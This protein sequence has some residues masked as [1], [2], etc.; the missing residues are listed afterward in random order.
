MERGFRRTLEIV[1]I[2]QKELILTSKLSKELPDR[3][4]QAAKACWGQKAEGYKPSATDTDVEMAGPGSNGGDLESNNKDQPTGQSA[5]DKFEAELK[6]AN[7]QVIKVDDVLMKDG[8]SLEILQ[9]NLDP[10]TDAVPDSVWGHSSWGESASTLGESTWGAGNWGTADSKVDAD[11][12]A[13]PV[14]DWAPPEVHSLIPLM[15]P[16]ALPITHTTGIV[17]WSVRRIKSVTAP[18]DPVTFPKSPIS[19]DVPEEDPDAVDIELERRF[20]KVVLEPWVGWDKE[21][22]PHLAHPRILETS[23]GLV[24]GVVGEDGRVEVDV[25]AAAVGPEAGSIKPHDPFKDDITLFVDSAALAVFSV[26]LG[27]GGTWVQMVRPQDLGLAGSK[28]KKKKK[29]KS[30]QAP[31][32]YWYVDELLMILP[33][34]YT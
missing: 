19:G 2:A 12:W 21:E 24:A 27:L 30:K 13:V 32:R 33:S 8:A 7:V 9:D 18:P 17:E 1:S 11:P 20:A 29:S 23:R 3:F 31:Q 14:V 26:G 10:V 6:A 4:S 34:Y 15:G 28:K 16:T 25:G 22:V 5:V